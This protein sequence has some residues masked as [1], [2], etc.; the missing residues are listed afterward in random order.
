CV[1]CRHSSSTDRFIGARCVNC[2][3]SGCSDVAGTLVYTS[4]IAS[5]L[6]NFKST[7]HLSTIARWAQNQPTNQPT[8][9]TT[10]QPNSQRTNQPNSQPTNQPTNKPNSQPTNQPTNRTSI[11]RTIIRTCHTSSQRNVF[12]E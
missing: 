3:P 2:S 10:N 1:V 7:T 9:Q 5:F 12:F 11:K 8:N 6:T 4:H